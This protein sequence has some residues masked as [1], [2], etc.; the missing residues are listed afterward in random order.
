MGNKKSN[1]EMMDDLNGYSSGTPPQKWVPCDHH[2]DGGYYV[3]DNE[4]GGAEDYQRNKK[5][6]AIERY[7]R[8]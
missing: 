8:S 6:D 5:I 7:L 4:S 2:P 1:K 3:D